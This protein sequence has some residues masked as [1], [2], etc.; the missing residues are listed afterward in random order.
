MGSS[1]PRSNIKQSPAI[2]VG[3]GAPNNGIVRCDIKATVEAKSLFSAD[4]PQ[5]PCELETFDGTV[6][7]VRRG[8]AIAVLNPG[9]IVDRLVACMARGFRY[10]AVVDTSG[11]RPVVTVRPTVGS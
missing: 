3:E 6:V 7:A 4:A 9:D 11:D 10:G 8:T 5:T 2:G 1:K